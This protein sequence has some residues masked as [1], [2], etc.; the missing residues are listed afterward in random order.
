MDVEAHGKT[1]AGA[2]VALDEVREPGGEED[3]K[4][5]L[6]ITHHGGPAYI[7][8]DETPTVTKGAEPVSTTAA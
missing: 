1:S 3:E 4:A 5:G 2:C 6:D 8:T 7:F